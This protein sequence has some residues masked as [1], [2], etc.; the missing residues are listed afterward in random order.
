MKLEITRHKNWWS[1]HVKQEVS[2]YTSVLHKPRVFCFTPFLWCFVL[3]CSCW[4]FIS[5][6]CAFVKLPRVC[7]AKITN[8]RDRE[9]REVLNYMLSLTP[10]MPSQKDDSSMQ[11]SLLDRQRIQTIKCVLFRKY[12]GAW[13][14][15]LT[16][17]GR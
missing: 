17:L 13:K 9:K 12:T 5:W 1:Y 16:L 4:S 3:S 10:I 7:G 11:C 2:F 15:Y 6:K 8:K 14:F